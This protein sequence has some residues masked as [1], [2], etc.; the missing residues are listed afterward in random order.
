MNGSRQYVDYSKTIVVV[1]V[2]ALVAGSFLLASCTGAPEDRHFTIGL[3]TNSSNGLRNVQG[4][5]DGMTELGYVEGGNVTYIFEGSPTNKDDLDD[6]LESM[7]EAKVDLIFTAG[8]PTGVAAHRVTA[9]TDVPVVF[10]VIADPIAAG[11]MEDLTTPGGNMTGVRLSQS[12]ARRLELL[13]KIAPGTQRVF[14]PYD[15]TDAASSSAVTQI[16][17]LAP[18]LGIEIVEGKASSDDQVTELLAKVPEGID[19]IFLVPGTTVNNRL[20]D[21]L[22]VALDRKL[23]VSGPSTA[24]VEE[25]ALTT[26]GF[27]H[28]QVGAQAARIADQILKGTDPGNL[29]VETAEC[30]LAINLQAADAI[31]LEIPY[32]ILQQAEIIIRADKED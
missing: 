32:E 16:N 29:P 13:L 20:Q 26:F 7:V 31:G 4:F 8:T 5:R 18:G 19:A 30:Y 6:V 2:A 12:Q 25:G 10:G 3:V 11:V 24:Q 17:E 1:I 9:G 22:A 14:V 23:P 28:H 21:I 27:I 15:P